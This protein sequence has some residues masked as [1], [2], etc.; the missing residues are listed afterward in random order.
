MIALP[1][2]AL[3]GILLGGALIGLGAGFAMGLVA[4]FTAKGECDQ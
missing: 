2:A 4:G 3:A 1:L